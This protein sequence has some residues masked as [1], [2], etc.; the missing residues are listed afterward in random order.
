MHGKEIQIPIHPVIPSF[1]SN[2][3]I[4]LKFEPNETWIILHILVPFPSNEAGN[5]LIQ[6]NPRTF[7]IHAKNWFSYHPSFPLESKWL[8]RHVPLM[9]NV[10]TSVYNCYPHGVKKEKKEKYIRTIVNIGVWSGEGQSLLPLLYIKHKPYHRRIHT[11]L[12]LLQIS[13]KFSPVVKQS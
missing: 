9:G 5:P 11:C 4:Q 13:V 6:M 7:Q 2:E 3:E 1:W 8:L 10:A 12:C